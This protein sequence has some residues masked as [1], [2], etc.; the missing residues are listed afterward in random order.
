MGPL[1]HETLTRQWAVE[2]G[3]ADVA[4]AIAK[5][6]VEFDKLFPGRLPMFW[7]LH[8][9]P[10]AALIGLVRLEMGVRARSPRVFGWGLHGVQ[11]YFAH[12]WLGEKHLLLRMRL[13]RRHPDIWEDAPPSIQKRIES[14]SRHWLRRYAA[15]LARK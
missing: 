3:L 15:A 14:A 6:N 5:A 12:G 10:L 2:E 4:D 8:L 11:D 1:V 13:A 7:G 9:G